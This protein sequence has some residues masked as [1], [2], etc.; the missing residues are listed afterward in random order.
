VGIRED[1]V[2]REAESWQGF[3]H[4]V[5]RLSPEQQELEGVVPGWS[6]KDLVWHCGYW[7]R[8]VIQH[9]PALMDGT[10]VDPFEADD[11]LGDR[12]NADIA[13]ESK[14][15]TFDE[16]LAKAEGARAEV[17]AVWSGLADE[18]TPAA[19]EWF[20]E[21]TFIHYDEHAPEIAKFADGLGA[22]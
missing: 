10:F 21:E 13:E 9:L 15:M 20:A 16:A 5:R 12:M 4:Q 8:D 1:H 11:M 19:A 3:L 18:P 22:A 17:I 14:T 6:T 2:K 7:A